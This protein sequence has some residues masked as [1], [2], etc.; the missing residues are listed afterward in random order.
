MIVG[1]G[2]SDPVTV[3]YSVSPAANFNIVFPGDPADIA[4][5]STIMVSI[6]P[7]SVVDPGLY[8]ITFTANDGAHAPQ[9]LVVQVAVIA[10][11]ALLVLQSPANGAT[12]VDLNP[13]LDW[14]S[15]GFGTS[16][17]IEIATDAGF[18]DV[19]ESATVNTAGYPVVNELMLDA[20]YFW[21]VTAQNNCGAF[22]A[23]EFNFA[24]KTTGLSDLFGKRGREAQHASTTTAAQSVD[25]LPIWAGQLDAVM[26]CQCGVHE[27]VI[28]V[29][30]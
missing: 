16:Y 19:V 21:R 1:N 5:G 2:F 27:T 18:V 17:F 8:M 25:P 20:T 13:V 24:T 29:Q 22:T 11:P 9:Q 14:A 10:Q 28:G 30:Q 26:A 15:L 3:S 6:D 7:G 12:S 4:P 23:E